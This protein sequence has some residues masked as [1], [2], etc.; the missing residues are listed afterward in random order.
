MIAIDLALVMIQYSYLA[1]GDAVQGCCKACVCQG[2]GIAWLVDHE[3]RAAARVCCHKHGRHSDGFTASL[4]MQ[5]V[6]V[7]CLLDGGKHS[8]SHRIFNRF[9]GDRAH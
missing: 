2:K 4:P 7:F 1:G 3:L 9:F 6:V 5:K 8:G